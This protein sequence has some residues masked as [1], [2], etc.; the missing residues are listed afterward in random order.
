MTSKER[1]EEYDKYLKFSSEIARE[2]DSRGNLAD[3]AFLQADDLE[4]ANEMSRQ[5]AQNAANEND[6]NN[7]DQESDALKVS[8]A[9]RHPFRFPLTSDEELQKADP[10]DPEELERLQE[11]APPTINDTAP[12]EDP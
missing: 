4:A 11:T 12:P 2:V 8:F 7:A 1:Q 10:Y 9:R 5:A 6:T 3:S